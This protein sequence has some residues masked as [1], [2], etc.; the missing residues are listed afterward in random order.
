MQHNRQHNRTVAINP[1]RSSLHETH[2]NNSVYK[3]INKS[4]NVIN[5]AWLL[6]PALLVHGR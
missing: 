3:V 5:K 2:T 4:L 1:R 6:L